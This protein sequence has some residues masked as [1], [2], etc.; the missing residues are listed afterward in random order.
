[1]TPRL[2]AMLILDAQGRREESWNKRTQ[3]YVKNNT[4]A[5]AE[6]LT[7]LNR[8][9]SEQG[10]ERLSLDWVHPVSLLNTTAWN[11]TQ[12]WAK[13]QLTREIARELL[14]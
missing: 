10:E 2:F 5:A 4:F 3:R 11:D 13:K 8:E 14:R 9:R 12:D 6:A 7:K 1:M